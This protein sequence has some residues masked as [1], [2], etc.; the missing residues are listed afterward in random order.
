MSYH[1]PEEKEEYTLPVYSDA[2]DVDIDPSLIADPETG[3]AVKSNLRLPPP[4]VFSRQTIP[5]I[6]KFSPMPIILPICIDWFLSYKGNP[7]S[8]V[9]TYVDEET[10]EEKKRLI[11]R[12]RWKGF[13]PIAINFSDKG[14]CHL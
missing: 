3:R 12:M 8:V 9:T 7:A 5:Q 2:M 10:G 11:N 6:Y 13:G 1:I 4:P 14:V